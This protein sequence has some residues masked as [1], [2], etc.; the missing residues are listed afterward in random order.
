MNNLAN[1]NVRYIG[2][3]LNNASSSGM[4]SAYGKYGG[5][6]GKYGGQYGK[7]GAY[8]KVRN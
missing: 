4:G 1:I 7:Y 2:Y 5:A 6:Y 3:V 8:S